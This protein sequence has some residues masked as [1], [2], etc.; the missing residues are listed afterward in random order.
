MV[1][2]WTGAFDAFASIAASA[3]QTTGCY[4]HRDAKPCG[5]APG[6]AQ[7]AVMS[8]RDAFDRVLASL[9]EAPL[10]DA[11][12][13]ATA[14]LIDDACRTSGNGLMV[15]SG[16]PQDGGGIFFASFC[17]HG[18]RANCASVAGGRFAE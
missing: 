2:C 17:Y 15:G 9:Y 3:S 18:Q 5:V 11:H 8:Q 4:W 16:H 13:P 10:D 6:G 7:K 12:W 1:V 14:G